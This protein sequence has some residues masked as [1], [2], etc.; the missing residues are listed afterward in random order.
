MGVLGRPETA[1]V[2]RCS[3]NVGDTICKGCGRTVQE[4]LE[5]NTYDVDT[6]RAMTITART[7]L[8]PSTVLPN[9]EAQLHARRRYDPKAT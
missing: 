1:C 4:V 6:R 5:W 9:Q 3:H 8:I 2:G 7:R